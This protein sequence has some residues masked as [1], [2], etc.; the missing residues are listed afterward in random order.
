MA[1]LLLVWDSIAA[2]ANYPPTNRKTSAFIY[3]LDNI[4]V[5]IHMYLYSRVPYH[6]LCL[7]NPCMLEGSSLTMQNL[8][9]IC[10]GPTDI[11]RVCLK[12][13]IGIVVIHLLYMGYT[14]NALAAI[15]KCRAF[16]QN[17]R[18]EGT[19]V[20]R[21]KDIPPPPPPHSD[22]IIKSQC[23]FEDKCIVTK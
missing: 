6:P 11:C 1:H 18:G 17:R 12:A 7:S 10:S 5:F 22:T 2:L 16:V 14:N 15:F 13:Q 23:A 20:G 8:H 19:A 21:E 4:I 3:M 9:T